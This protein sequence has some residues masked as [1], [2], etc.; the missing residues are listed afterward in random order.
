MD[1]VLS[2]NNRFQLPRHY[3]HRRPRPRAIVIEGR[4]TRLWQVGRDFRNYVSESWLPA[5]PGRW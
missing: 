4:L 1:V 3:R 5:M 2:K